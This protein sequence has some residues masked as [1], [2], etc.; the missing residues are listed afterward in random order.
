MKKILPILIIFGAINFLASAQSTGDYRS[1][2]SG[3]WNDP[4][5]WQTYNGNNWVTATTY[6]GQHPGSGAPS[7]TNE[8]EITITSS[9]PYALSSLKI[10]ADLYQR[11]PAGKLTFRA[12]NAVSLIVS[13]AV[14]V[15]GSITVADQIGTKGH[16]LIIGGDLEAGTWLNVPDPDCSVDPECWDCYPCP[17]LSYPIGG[18]IETINIDDKLAVLFNTTTENARIRGSAAITFQDVSFNGLGISVENSVNIN[19][20]ATFIKGVI[21]HGLYFKDG[22]SVIGASANSF[23]NGLVGKQGSGSFTFP[24]GA[25]GIYSPLTATLPPGMSAILYARYT[26]SAVWPIVS[27]GITDQSLYSVSDCEYWELNRGTYNSNDSIDFPVDITIGWSASSACSSSPYVTNVSTVSMANLNV[28]LKSWETHGGSPI[29]TIQNGTV[30]WSGVKRLGVFTLGN[31]NNNCLPPDTLTTSEIT[32]SL[33]V[34]NWSTVPGATSY[35]VDYKRNTTERWTNIATGTNTTTLN[36][37][38]LIAVYSYDW[39]VRTN[40]SSSSSAYRMTRFDPIYPCGTPS[41]LTA[42]NITISGAKLSW[43]PLTNASSYSVAY[44]Q[45]NSISWTDA[46]IN[47][48][49]T[50]YTLTGLSSATSYDWRVFPLCTYG[51]DFDSWGGSPA[52]ASF[53]T[54]PPPVCNN[55]FEANNSSSQAKT[56]SPGIVASESIY[57]ATDSDWFKITTSNSNATLQVTLNNLPADYDLYLYNKS[58]KLINS[59]TAMGISSE[60]VVHNLGARKE[61]FYIKVVAKKGEYNTLECYHLLAQLFSVTASALRISG[62]DAT[63]RDV[64]G[65]QL[66]YPNPAS[67]DLYLRFNSMMQGTGTIQISNSLGQLVKQH[68][69][70]LTSGTNQIKIAVGNIRPG[71]YILKMKMDGSN[72]LKKFTIAR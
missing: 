3:N 67:N 34:L 29:G 6:P 27:W 57:S 54:Q 2:G 33:A 35:D 15:Y 19:G 38:G 31:I 62:S 50:S 39:R 59:S 21:N 5:K 44:K 53:T 58:V 11:V 9:V 51:T 68:S 66:L 18:S 41:G 16:S 65:T 60:S 43:S 40:C 12:A 23:V 32:S 14:A 71:T 24:I 70:N 45:S 49:A 36:L 22:A 69:I 72:L 37:Y 56:I 42:S 48:G 52:Q 10:D 64:A 8:T 4:T 25:N 20:I 26:R 7:I 28:N 13:G 47:I 63:E 55:S 1:V 30:T 17:Y 46:A 61:T